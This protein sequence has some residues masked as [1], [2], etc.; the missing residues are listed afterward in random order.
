M[1]NDLNGLDVKCLITWNINLINFMRFIHFN[2]GCSG[3][4]TRG[5]VVPLEKIEGVRR[6]PERWENKG[7]ADNGAYP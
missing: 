1:M 4:G 7:Y 2:Q 6:T 3:G 5:Y